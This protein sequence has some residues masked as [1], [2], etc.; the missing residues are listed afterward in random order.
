[1]V[2]AAGAGVTAVDHE[3]VGAEPGLAC[4]LVNR[5]G[6]V[7]A[8]PPARGGMDVDLDHAGIGRDADDVDALILRRGIA[9][10]MHG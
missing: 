8:F 7:D 10:D 3:L 6:D 2:A 4:L 5:S 1:M 9:L